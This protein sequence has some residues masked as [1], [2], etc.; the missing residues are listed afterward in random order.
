[1]E[2]QAGPADR[3][4]E[5]LVKRM[6]LL[7]ACDR[8]HATVDGQRDHYDRCDDAVGIGSEESFGSSELLRATDK[9]LYELGEVVN[10]LSE[11]GCDVGK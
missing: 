10:H 6:R 1:M 2:V 5:Q 7:F 3:I 11:A 9:G 4:A 8:T